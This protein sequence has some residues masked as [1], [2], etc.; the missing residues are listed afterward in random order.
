MIA[1]CDIGSRSESNTS[2]NLI[3]DQSAFLLRYDRLVYLLKGYQ[4]GNRLLSAVASGREGAA[5]VVDD[6]LF[7]DDMQALVV[8]TSLML[9]KLQNSYRVYFWF[10][11]LS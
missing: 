1:Y 11:L 8:Y 9:W 4:D 7:S 5:V 10:N 2:L 6:A 3:C